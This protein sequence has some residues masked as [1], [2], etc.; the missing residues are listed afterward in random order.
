MHRVER[1]YE[2][3]V[4]QIIQKDELLQKFKLGEK[5]FEKILNLFEVEKFYL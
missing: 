3:M 2:F 1:I 5:S 4:E